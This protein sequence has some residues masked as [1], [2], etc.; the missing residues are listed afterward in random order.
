MAYC[1]H[2]TL[3]GQWNPGIRDGRAHSKNEGRGK[4]KFRLEHLEKRDHL[5]DVLV[6]GERI[7][8][9]H[10][11]TERNRSDSIHVYRDMDQWGALSNNVM[12][13]RVP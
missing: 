1:V 7:E 13:F 10:N 12:G 11:E 6:R 3:L 5:K 2:Q 8:M 9:D 4:Y